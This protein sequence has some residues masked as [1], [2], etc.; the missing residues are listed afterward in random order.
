M[1]TKNAISS[2]KKN[3]SSDD[4]SM[5]GIGSFYSKMKK[6][7]LMATV[8]AEFIGTFM[9]V[10]AVFAVQ[11]QPLYVGFVLIG[12]V[13]AIGGISGA[14]VNPAMTIGAWVTR[15]IGSLRM[16]GYIVAQVL[17]AVAAWLTLNAF[18][19]SAQSSSVSGQTLFHAATITSGKEWPLFFAE[20]LGA[21][22]LGLGLAVAL[23]MKREKLSAAFT[24]GLAILIALLVAGWVTSMSLTESNTGLSFLNPA[25]AIAAN[26]LSWNMWPI[27]IYIIAPALGGIIGFALQDI[28]KSQVQNDCD[29]DCGCKCCDSDSCK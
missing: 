14:Y 21:T 8:I 25:I 12:I 7:P 23:R 18:L 24:Y 17:G 9:L 19:H 16:I 11:G 2:N 6:M 15:K 29:C 10:A 20:L 1:A 3:M 4:G 26:G 22:I 5:S 27:A 13:L 28:L